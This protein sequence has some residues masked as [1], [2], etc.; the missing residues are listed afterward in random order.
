MLAVF[1]GGGDSI[2]WYWCLVVTVVLAV[3][4][5]EWNDAGWW[6]AVCVRVEPTGGISVRLTSP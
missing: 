2:D 3:A 4:D 6:L 1:A 5:G